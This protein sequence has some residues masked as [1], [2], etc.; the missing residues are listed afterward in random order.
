MQVMPVAPP[1][2]PEYCEEII[3]DGRKYHAC[4]FP[5]CG[6]VFRFKSEYH[7]HKLTHTPQRPLDCPFVGCSKSFKREDALKNH[8][9]I[10]TGE[11][12]FRCEE[13]ECGQ[14]FPT[15]AGLRYH[16]LK[17]KGDKECR[18]SFPGCN[19]TF[20]TM[21]QLKQHESALNYHQK[22]STVQTVVKES[23]EFPADPVKVEK[24]K[25]QPQAFVAPEAKIMGK[26][27][28]QTKDQNDI[29]VVEDV[30]DDIQE[31][32]ERMVKVILTENNAMKK[33]LNMCTTL[34][35]LIEENKD[36]KSKLSRVSDIDEQIQ[37]PR[38]EVSEEKIFAFLKFDNQ[39][40]FC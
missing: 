23:Q 37:L 27:E 17:H 11:M 8:M 9:R 39:D 7:R 3:R 33:R 22:I 16:V 4:T 19:K 32:F 6:K 29:T 10:H 31:D 1:E 14:S 26:L 18:C 13:P 20:L 12:P 36:L 28:W 30:G 21:S 35:G 24:S 34:K 5:N 38:Q 2:D 15:K 40:R 25:D